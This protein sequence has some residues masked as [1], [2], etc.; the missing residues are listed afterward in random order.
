[1]LSRR[2]PV[3]RKP[4]NLSIDARLIAE[5]KDLDINISR[6]AEDGIARAVA[7]EK[8]RLWK[9]ENREAIESLNAYIE[10]NGLPLEEFRQF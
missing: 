3:Q 2:P 9:I 10:E 1:M 7:E 4:T 6:I 8:A 5:A